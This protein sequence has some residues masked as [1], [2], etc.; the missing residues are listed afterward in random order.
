MI[1]LQVG[2]RKFPRNGRA[3]ANREDGSDAEWRDMKERRRSSKRKA[4]TATVQ[5]DDGAQE[6]LDYDNYEDESD[7]STI[8]V[9]SDCDSDLTVHFSDTAEEDFDSDRSLVCQPRKRSREHPM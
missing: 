9:I 8:S 3:Y 5:K 6:G 1:Q 4:S 7:C 2:R